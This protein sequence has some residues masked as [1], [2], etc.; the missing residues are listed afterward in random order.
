MTATAATALRV[1]PQPMDGDRPMEPL[2]LRREAAAAAL[3]VSTK[4]FDR[5]VRPYLR[6]VRLGSTRVYPVA[7]LEAFL[8]DQA[9]SPVEDIAA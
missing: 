5:Y 9:S 4:T 2:G 3:G 8:A 7:A 1:A 6:V